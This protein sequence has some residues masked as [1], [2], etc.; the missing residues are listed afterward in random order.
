MHLYKLAEMK[1]DK[2]K[3]ESVGFYILFRQNLKTHR[4]KHVVISENCKMHVNSQYAIDMFPVINVAVFLAAAPSFSTWLC[5]GAGISLTL[6]SFPLWTIA[7]LSD[8]SMCIH[9]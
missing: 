5:P 4:N 1:I 2:K 8:T 9:C 3:K 6:E 7:G